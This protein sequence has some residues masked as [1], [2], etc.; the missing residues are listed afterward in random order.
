LRVNTSTSTY[1]LAFIYARNVEYNA[2]SNETT[3]QNSRPHAIC[4]CQV[5]TYVDS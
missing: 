2:A 4:C 5:K 1:K 3:T